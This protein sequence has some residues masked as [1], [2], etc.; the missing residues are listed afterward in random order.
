ME[1]KFGKEKVI[2]SL[3]WKL[4]ERSGVQGIQFFL[5]IIL[6][7]ILTPNDYGIIAIISTFIVIAN[8]FVQSGFNTALIQNK[9]VCDE[10][11]SSV[12]YLSMFVAACVY[13]ILFFT[14]PLIS[15]FYNVSE[16]TKVIRIL[17]LTLFLGAYNSIQN[18]IVARNMQF[19]KLFF[20]SSVA[21]LISGCVGVI[22]AYLQF[23]V[24]ALVA[25]QLLNQIIIILILAFTLS[26]KPKLKFS[27]KRVRILFKYG[28][29]LLLSS[30]I[31][32]LYMNIRSLIVGK[33]YHPAVLGFYNR[34]D[35][36]P[37]LIV[38]NINGSIQSV[39]LP[40]LSNE[41]ENKEKVK[42]MVRRAIVTSSFIVF[43][44]MIGL[45]VVAEPVVK[46]LLTDKWLPCVPFIQ[47]FCISYALWPIH[48]ANL[49]AIN[50][51]GH[52]EIYLQLELVKKVV[53]TIILIVSLFF[54][55]YAIAIGTLI[56]G[57]IS[58]FINSY[59]NKKLLNYSYVE[60]IK[61][62]LPP[63]AIAIIMGGITYLVKFLGVNTLITLI[64]QILVGGISYI[65]LANIFKLECYIYLL[66]TLKTMI[67]RKKR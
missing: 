28:W 12:L 23:E 54:G 49:Q 59:P 21:I 5:Q 65:V 51:L 56:S 46:I 14:A 13:F 31:D 43:P 57:I 42:N 9:D 25:Q 24:W 35:Q 61:D 26:W 41:Q 58:T 32:T 55:V 10:D 15:R 4:L 63:L 53:G 7:R 38:S 20:S 8:V 50:A 11:F 37:K 6:A 62:I 18:A 19:K 64:I 27:Y 67:N 52:S 2:K 36:F 45:A 33:I 48:T 44:M 22:L 30:L 1:F 16:L 3:V 29:K 39:M 34:G 66:E 60:Q 47:I 40:A 17:S